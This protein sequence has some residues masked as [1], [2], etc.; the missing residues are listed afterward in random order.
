MDWSGLA[1]PELIGSVLTGLSGIFAAGASFKFV[2]EGRLGLRLRFGRV[3][4][5]RKGEPKVVHPGFIFVWPFIESLYTHPVRQQTL[6]CDKQEV[7][8]RDGGVFR[9]E[10]IVVYRVVDV[11]RALFDIADLEQAIYAVA[12]AALRESLKPL[13]SSNAT[14]SS[15]A[16]KV[17]EELKGHAENWGIEVIQVGFADFSPTG[18]TNQLLLTESLAVAR[19]GAL[20]RLSNGGKVSDLNP[21]LA[22]A[23]I[24]TPIG[25]TIGTER[26]TRTEVH[27]SQEEGE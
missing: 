11:Y 17:A 14:D 5:D 25:V 24:G 3:L 22:A 6:S 23:L 26:H 10:T 9:V 19:H 2:R 8:L 15:L 7:M 18:M 12:M 20:A 27:H 13:D 4:R 21:G 16:D 1:N